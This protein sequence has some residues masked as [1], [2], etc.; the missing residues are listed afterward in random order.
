MSEE[1][2]TINLVLG[3]IGTITGVIALFI[4]FWTLRKERPH[5]EVE[6]LECEHNFGMS[7][8]QTMLTF[9]V[10]FQIK[11]RGDRGTSINDIDLTFE[12][13]EKEYCFKKQY[14]R[15]QGGERR[16]VNAHDTIKIGA[17]FYEPFEGS[18]KEQIECTFTLYHT[19]GAK[20]NIKSISQRRL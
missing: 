18:E 1:L 16:W 3:I 17:D 13:D 4:S 20:K 8:S 6:V 9:W 12:D 2:S 14:F 7:E 15:G 5:L 19:H 11:N 10:K